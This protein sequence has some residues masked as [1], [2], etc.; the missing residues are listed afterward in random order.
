MIRFNLI[1]SR[2]GILNGNQENER[3]SS[4]ARPSWPE[5]ME[6]E[7]PLHRLEGSR[8]H[9]PGD[10]RGQG[11]RPQAEGA[12]ADLRHRIYLGAQARAAHARPDTGR[13]RP[14]TRIADV[15]TPVT[16]ITRI[17]TSA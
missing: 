14:D 3:P 9:R 12:G 15:S 6:L 17:P 1:G 8:S 13:D 7:E 2:S 11:G 5:R 4:R 10:R 16:P